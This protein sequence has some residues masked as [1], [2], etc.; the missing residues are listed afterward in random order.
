LDSRR[1]ANEL[2]TVPDLDTPFARKL[3]E[4]AKGFEERQ[5]LALVVQYTEKDK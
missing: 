4:L 1:V 2:S 3:R 5:I